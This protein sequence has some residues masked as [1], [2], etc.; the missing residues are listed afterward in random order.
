[1]GGVGSKKKQSRYIVPDPNPESGMFF[2][3]DQLPFA[4]EGVPSI[5]VLGYTD[6]QKYSKEK[7]LE[8]ITDYWRNTYHKPQ[9]EYV[10]E[11]DNLAGLVDDACLLCN[12]EIN[13]ANSNEWPAWNNNS[14]FKI[15]RE[16]SIANKIIN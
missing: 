14:E 4:K 12:V 5:F 11:R 7:T 15:I 13:L 1:M 2:R 8:L 6:A 16:N 3:S 9:D 10:P